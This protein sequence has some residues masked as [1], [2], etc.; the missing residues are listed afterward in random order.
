MKPVHCIRFTI[1]LSAIVLA[2]SLLASCG[3]LNSPSSLVRSFY[4]AIDKAQHDKAFRCFEPKITEEGGKIRMV[5]DEFTK[6]AKEGGGIKKVEIISETIRP[7]GKVKVD[8][9][10][11]LGNGKTESDSILAVKIKGRWYLTME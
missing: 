8:Y 10:L 6:K 2:A 11:H 7:D 3:F 9:R 4:S 1:T 5:V